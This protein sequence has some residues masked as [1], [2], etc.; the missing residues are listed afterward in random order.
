MLHV[1]GCSDE[2]QHLQA[3]HCLHWRMVHSIMNVHPPQWMIPSASTVTPPC[4]VQS[5]SVAL[6]SAPAVHSQ[7]L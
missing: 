5:M 1:C 4:L 3:W 2:L 6:S 7:R